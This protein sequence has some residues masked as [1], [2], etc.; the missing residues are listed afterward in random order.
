MKSLKIIQT[1]CKLGKIFSKI[2]FI[3]AIIGCA[4]CLVGILA[5]IAAGDLSVKIGGESLESLL[6]VEAGIGVGTI[7]ASIFVGLF[8]C[9]AQIVVSKMACNYFTHELAA[10]TP[11]TMEGA[12]EL[13]H[14]GIN[15]IWVPLAGIVLASVSQGIIGALWEDVAPLSLDNG[16]SLVLGVCFIIISVLCRYGAELQKAE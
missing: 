16:D 13:M 5:L 10:G 1:L 3:C 8:L 14:L 2:V 15:T 4:G 9:G 12:K 11:F 7:W 6:W